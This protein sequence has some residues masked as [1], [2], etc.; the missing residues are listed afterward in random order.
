MKKKIVSVLLCCA[1]VATMAAGCGSEK[2]D[3][4]DTAASAGDDGLTTED[5]TLK[6]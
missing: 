2:K 6:V 4:V 1:I 3:A 5:V